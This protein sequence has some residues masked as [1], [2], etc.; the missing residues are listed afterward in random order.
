MK[1][2]QETRTG[3]FRRVI[4]D[5]I[6]REAFSCQYEETPLQIACSS[7]QGTEQAWLDKTLQARHPRQPGIIYGFY[8]SDG[9]LQ[10]QAIEQE[11]VAPGFIAV[12]SYLVVS[13]GCYIFGALAHK[14]VLS[15]FGN[16][17]HELSPEELGPGPHLWVKPRDPERLKIAKIAMMMAMR[18]ITAHEMIHI[19]HGHIRHRLADHAHGEMAEL[20]R[21]LQP[22]DA[23]F[24]QT[25]EMDADAGAVVEC[26]PGVILA[27]W[28]LAEVIRI[29]CHPVYRTP[30]LALRL[31]LFAVYCVFRVMEDAS[32]TCS[33]ETASH[34]RPM[35]RIRLVM[36]TLYES[37]KQNKLDRLLS[38]IAELIEQSIPDGE[39]AYASIINC[40]P[41]LEQIVTSGTGECQKRITEIIQAWRDVRPVIE[42][43]AR[44]SET[45]APLPEGPRTKI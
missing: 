8:E 6:N 9:E 23:L 17:N 1:Q 24:S 14:S 34:P 44:E 41:G 37:L 20:G 32:G 43:Y 21:V 25:L 2:N 29:D 22:E 11:G 16:A 31:W 36:N 27:E 13:L 7:Y 38:F 35:M 45:L 10:A 5:A 18:F 19:L 4:H 15:D 3:M 42:P 28:D 26:M 30:E 40:P 39:T 12:S 33:V